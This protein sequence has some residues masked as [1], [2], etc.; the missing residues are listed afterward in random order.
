MG[1]ERFEDE[2][3]EVRQVEALN[4]MSTAARIRRA[5][6]A[7]DP[8]PPQRPAH[9]RT[10]P[11][12]RDAALLEAGYG[13][14]GAT[15]MHHVLQL[16]SQLHD[17][18]FPLD[19]QMVFSVTEDA[20]CSMGRHN[21][22]LNAEEPFQVRL[23]SAY[24]AA[25]AARTA[26]PVYLAS[27]DE[28][29]ARFPATYQLAA[30]VG[31]EAWACLPLTVRGELVGVWLAAFSE[32]VAFTADEQDLLELTAELLTA[33]VED[34]QAAAA[35][36]TLSQ[37]LRH[38]M[39]QSV[40]PQGLTVAARY[41][42]TGG[43]LLVGG[44]WY[45][46]IRLHNGNLALVIGDVEGSD[47]HAAGVMSQLR[48]AVHAYAL[49]GH[50]PDSV[51]TRA[52]RFLSGQNSERFATCLYAEADP[53][54]GK[55]HLARAGHPHPVL[56]LPDGT[57]LLKH[58]P[59]GLPLGLM[60]EADD[61]PVTTLALAGDEVLML[62][63]DGLIES[64]GHDM[65]TGWVRL[66]D[67]MSPAPA[68][69]LEGMAERLLHVVTDSLPPHADR[70]R[71]ARADDMALLL[72]RRDPV[73]HTAEPPLRHLALTVTQERADGVALAR[74]EISGLLHDWSDADRVDS[75]V[76]LTTELIGNVMVHTDAPASVHADLTSH[77]S[78]YVGVT[79]GGDDMPHQLSPGELAPGG[80]GLM[81]LDALAAQWGVRPE[82][83]GKTVWFVISDAETAPP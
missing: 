76:L 5:P 24:P 38:S 34:M 36:Y 48:T 50:G 14:S 74:Q 69:D 57:C 61:Y 51:L 83:E 58:I 62:C 10:A 20:L 78:L 67:V 30:R 53:T 15:S 77:H 25:E 60:P 11:R 59:G 80:R 7:A 6:P 13:M 27:P 63:T 12:R 33:A 9:A 75:A 66:R 42:P 47:V 49:E 35:E 28:Y 19:G 17:E 40:A 45:D 72:V 29:A 32:P 71:E 46:C 43:G 4:D 37:R 26:E 68:G 21:M 44:D 2:S 64:G 56:R 79:D 82:A 1:R 31:H 8:R 55:L 54:S 39:D 22:P 23:D 18:R 41:V 73:G 81:L 16:A 3:E 70:R 65:Y 52:S